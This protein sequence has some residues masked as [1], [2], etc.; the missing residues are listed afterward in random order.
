MK[1]ARQFI[2]RDCLGES[3]SAT[4]PVRVRRDG[5]VLR[6]IFRRGPFV[7]SIKPATGQVIAAANNHTCSITASH[8]TLT[9]RI[10]SAPIP[11]NKLPGYVHSVPTGPRP[12][13][14]SA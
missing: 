1:V 2:A 10:L 5:L 6:D 8:R 12:T 14:S 3:D 11:G 13:E 7:S 9:G 4:R